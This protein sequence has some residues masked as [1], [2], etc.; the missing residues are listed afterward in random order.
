[1]LPS[2]LEVEFI[3][4]GEVDRQLLQHRRETFPVLARA[5]AAYLYETC[6]PD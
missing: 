3:D 1:M 5:I 2:L 4:R 6:G